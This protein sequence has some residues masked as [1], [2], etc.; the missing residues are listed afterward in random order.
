MINPNPFAVKLT[1]DGFVADLS[2]TVAAD[3]CYPGL[4]EPFTTPGGE[5]FGM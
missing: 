3:N 1:E 5:V 2:D 4:L